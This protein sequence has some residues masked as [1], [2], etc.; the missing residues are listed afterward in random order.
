MKV[1]FLHYADYLEIGIPGGI[2]IL[3]A[4]LKAHGHEVEVFDTTFMKRPGWENHSKSVSGF[5]IFKKTEY[6]L[7]DLVREDPVIDILEEFKSTLA[8][9]NPDILAVSVMTANY[10]Q[11]LELVKRAKPECLTIFGGV[12]PTISPEE[13]INQ[14]VVNMLCLGEGEEAIVELADGLQNGNSIGEIKNLWTKTPKNRI[15]K[16]SFR[17]FIDLNSLPCPDWSVFDSRHLFRPFEGKVYRGSFVTS[18]R[19]CPGSCTYCVNMTIR[20]LFKG[21]GN[22]FRKANS[23]TFVSHLR[24]LKGEYEA[25]WFK[26]ADDTFLLRST[27][28]LIELKEGIKPLNI[29]FGCSVQPGTIDKEKVL[30][31]KEMG[32]VAMTV[33]I[34]TGNESLRWKILNRQISDEKLIEGIKIIREAGLRLSTF[35]M[36]GL[37]LETR[38]N[39]FETIRLN[40]ELGT[41]AANVYV[42]YPFPGTEIARK[43]QINHRDSGARMIPMDKAARFALSEMPEEEVDGLLKTFNLYLMLPEEYWGSIRQAEGNSEESQALFHKLTEIAANYT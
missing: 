40:R 21:S 28:E 8:R 19:G 35:N 25:T 14:D 3:S 5:A 33:G 23:K 32:C 10:D 6:T 26:F 37:P 1:L 7:E 38:E 31:A 15:V 30:L 41:R 27:R 43:H 2:S 13:V 34:E 36:L 24:R 4:V 39:V 18:S 20:N 11:A 12:H 16:N 17:K 29:M 42:L 9:Y 22:Y